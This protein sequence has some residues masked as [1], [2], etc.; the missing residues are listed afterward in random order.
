M[1]NIILV[2]II[3]FSVTS[4]ARTKLEP[5]SLSQVQGVLSANEELH[6]AFYQKKKAI[7]ESRAVAVS[8]KIKLVTDKKIK[9]Y[10]DRAD[11][12]LL[13]LN[14]SNDEKRN[15]WLYHLASKQFKLV[16]SKFEIAN[17]NV[18]SCPMIFPNKDAYWVQNSKKLAQLQNPYDTSMPHCGGKITDY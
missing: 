8:D 1:K 14:G 10:L 18:Y 12:N 5:T 17:Y 9:I 7:I 2:L 6:A 11:K 16:L 3:L 13:K 4:M 15:N